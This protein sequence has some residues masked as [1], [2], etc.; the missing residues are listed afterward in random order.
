MALT[1]FSVDIINRQGATKEV[2]NSGGSLQ[3]TFSDGSGFNTSL[4]VSSLLLSSIGDS[5]SGSVNSDVFFALKSYYLK[6]NASDSSASSLALLTI[7]TA[8][9]L[10]VTPMSLAEDITRSGQIMLSSDVYVV[11]NMFRS[12]SEKTNVLK[13]NDN[14]KSFRKR[15]VID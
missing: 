7:D 14:S 1:R 2:V 10:N 15:N 6:N 13:V 8:K 5:S 4:D 3:S 9:V 11:M 12:P